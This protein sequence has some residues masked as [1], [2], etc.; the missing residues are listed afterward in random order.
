MFGGADNES[1]ERGRR[2]S[3]A[4]NPSMENV[5]MGGAKVA[6]EQKAKGWSAARQR[7]AGVTAADLLA[8]GYTMAEIVAAGYSPSELELT[9]ARL[10]Q[11]VKEQVGGVDGDGVTGRLPDPHPLPAPNGLAD[12]ESAFL[13]TSPRSDGAV[14]PPPRSWCCGIGGLFA[15]LA[16]SIL[17]PIGGCA[18]MLVGVIGAV[19]L[20]GVMFY[21][22]L[23]SFISTQL[24]HLHQGDDQLP[25]PAPPSFPPP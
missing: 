7:A 8:A 9:V 18:L 16:K 4:L 20:I 2:K 24:G 14:A 19:P 22:L 23:L 21:M 13:G 1:R 12:E 15:C 10:V 11:T 25:P 6:A 17:G 5:G 3:L